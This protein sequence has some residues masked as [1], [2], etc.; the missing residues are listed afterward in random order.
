MSTVLKTYEVFYSLQGETLYSGFP[1]LFFRLAGCPLQCG[2]CDT[3]ASKAEGTPEKTATLLRAARDYI[4]AAHHFTVTGG[5]PLA[6]PETI[7]FLKELIELG[8]PVQLETSGAEEIEGLPRPLR[9]I[10]DVKTP[11]SGMEGRFMMENLRHLKQSDEIKFV[12]ADRDD[13]DFSRS[14]I[15][16]NLAHTEVPIN[17]SP[18]PGSLEPEILAQWIL[19]DR[20]P[21]R[22]NLQLH[23]YLWKSEDPFRL[24]LSAYR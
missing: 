11:G 7:P 12:L 3:Q 13:Y 24:D 21:V 5:E 1:S 15:F 20:L 8:K 16:Q 14:F 22:L 9:C 19:D 23:K 10:L 18:V 6:Q 17:L 2:W 4:D